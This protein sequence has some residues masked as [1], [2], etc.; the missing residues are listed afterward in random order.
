MSVFIVYLY[1]TE[2][3]PPAIMV[4]IRPRG[5]R[6]VSLREAPL[7]ASSSAMYASW[8]VNNTVYVLYSFLFAVHTAYNA[9]IALWLHIIT[10]YNSAMTAI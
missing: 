7:L 1:M 10:A 3:P 8:R 2:A 6:T 5:L 4:H 9:H